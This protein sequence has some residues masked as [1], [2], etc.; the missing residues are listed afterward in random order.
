MNT[1]LQHHAVL[2]TGG[3]GGIG[4]ALADAFL[5]AGA[6][7]VICA[8]SREAAA[9]PG[10]VADTVDV[11]SL[12]SVQAL[13]ARHA[14]AALSVVIHCAGVNGN[15]PITAPGFAQTARR[16]IEVNYLG[17]L[18]LAS[19]FAPLLAGRP[20]ATFVSMLSFLSHV[21]VPSMATYCASKAAA[22][23]LTQSLRQEL[24]TSGIRVCGVYPTAVDTVMSRDMPGPKLAPGDLARRVVQAVAQGQDEL[25]P[26]P[27]RERYIEVLAAQ[28]AAAAD[29]A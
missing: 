12:D 20:G 22:H 17:L 29:L 24:G 3:S 9:R 19:A 4:A 1:P 14:G 11:T 25:Y 18:H 23:S 5:E 21:S 15:S 26:A 7:R 6:R 28:A 27:A 8:S 13:A 10:I 2:L 16:E